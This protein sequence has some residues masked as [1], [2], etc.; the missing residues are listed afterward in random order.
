VRVQVDAQLRGSLHNILAMHTPREGFVFHLLIHAGRFHVGDGL[1]GLDEG[2]GVLSRPDE[3]AKGMIDPCDTMKS[4]MLIEMWER[5]R[6]YDKWVRTEA[7]IES[8]EIHETDIKNQYG[9]TMVKDYDAGD[10]IT[11]LDARGEKH[12]SKF[13]VGEVSPLYQLVD[14]QTFTIR[15]DPEHPER[16][17]HPDLLRYRAKVAAWATLVLLGIIAFVAWFIWMS[18]RQSN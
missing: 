3:Y 13:S 6:G 11:W 4:I 5:W 17:Y 1:G 2:A 12:Q 9:Q 7:K 8:S 18:I 15:Y 16:F 14:G 10:L